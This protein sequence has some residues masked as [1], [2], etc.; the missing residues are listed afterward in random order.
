MIDRQEIMDF[1]REFQLDPSIIEKDY[2]LGWLLAGISNYPQLESTWVFKGGTCL[3]KC[4]FETYRFS[5]DLD[6]TIT[7]PD[8]INPEFLNLVFSE[9]SQW[10]YD[11]SGI[12]I[13][14]ER[15]RF[16]IYK[17]PQGRTSVEGR[18]YYQGPLQRRGSLPRLKID[19]TH[20]EILV[21]NPIAR[22]IHHPY[23]DM[24]DNGFSIQCYCFE[25]V[26]A[27]KLRALA[28]RLR[29]RDL[30]DVVHLHRLDIL[31]VDLKLLV[32]TLEDK[33][34]FKSIAVP[35]MFILENK[36]EK[37]ELVTEWENM[38][39]HQLPML[40]PFEQFWEELPGLFE[41][42]YS[43]V[44]KVVHKPIP[45]PV[46]VDTK[47]KPPSMAHAWHTAV[48]LEAIR[49][50]AANRLCV[51][52]HYQGTRRLIEPYS[53]RR[54]KDGD[55]LLHAV[56]HNTGESRS[57]RIDRIQGAETTKIS[58]KPRYTIELIPS[59][60]IFTSP[61]SR[62]SKSPAKY[63]TISYKSTR[64]RKSGSRRISGQPAYIIQC[65]IC[66]KKF[67]RT[68]YKTQLNPHKNKEGYPCP[69]RI[70]Y[71]VDIKY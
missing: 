47:W 46:E 53:L 16:D 6:F 20:D 17:N 12:E 44:P 5:E 31:G 1:A 39:G 29:P 23:S 66:G 38:L 58:F 34:R 63:K 26:F 37:A 3:K 49:F 2:V 45:A 9:I 22:R 69:S 71:I 13:P 25:E 19:I 8:H 50:A 67:N 7:N 35:T 30:Y 60:P 54:T 43:L 11:E 28:E 36:P 61:T 48:P 65:T 15:L 59:G 55:I 40:P 33:C 18:I 62:K 4:Y 10:I 70:G 27:E 32:R 56:K 68:K 21:L 14:V 24:Q 42:L 57:Y 64:S 51:N 41:W 52:L